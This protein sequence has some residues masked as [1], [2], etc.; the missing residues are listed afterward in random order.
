MDIST[1]LTSIESSITS[2]DERAYFLIHEARYK[3]VLE[4]ISTI[5]EDGK[6]KIEKT[7][8][9]STVNFRSS[10][11]ILDVGC[12]P[13]HMGKALEEMGYEVWGIA[14]SHEPIVN[15][16]VSI[17]NIE[18]DRFP[19]KSN[20]FDLVLCSEVIEHLPHSPVPAMKEMYRVARRGGYV[21]ITTPNIAR[22]INQGKMLL[23]RAPMYSVDAFM[24]NEGK[25]SNLYHRHNREFTLSE[26][27]KL[28]KH[29]GW[30]VDK[31]IHFI[32]YPPFRR[33]NKSDNPFLWTGKLANYL[34]MKAFPR[35]SDTLLVIGQKPA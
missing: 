28:V 26:L 10:L 13:Y 5:I 30:K 2:N 32:S 9:S 23:G 14:S 33:R 20:M 19:Y 35:L 31:A 24:E 15:K 1:I 7:N 3:R 11:R 17:L 6:S 8:L 25:G 16:K 34:A 22:S 18:I 29:A 27:K 12:F 21:L 4:E